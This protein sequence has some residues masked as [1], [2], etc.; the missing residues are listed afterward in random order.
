[1]GH[2]RKSVL[3]LMRDQHELIRD[4]IDVLKDEDAS[5]KEK[6]EAVRE[7]A[8]LL[9]MH[10]QAEEET[11]YDALAEEAASEMAVLEAFEEHRIAEDLLQ[12]IEDRHTG[13]RWDQKLSAKAKVMAQLVEHHIEQEEDKIFD[14]AEEELSEEELIQLGEEFQAICDSFHD[15]DRNRAHQFESN[16]PTALM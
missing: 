4:V 3:K 6:T 13:S 1:M 12:E 11:I 8:H 5:T 10:S 2:K 15:E 16:Q 9:K 14:L 7:F